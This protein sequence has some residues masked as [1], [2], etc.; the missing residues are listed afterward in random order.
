M[1]CDSGP[2]LLFDCRLAV[3]CGYASGHVWHVG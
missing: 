3:A 2:N 1:E